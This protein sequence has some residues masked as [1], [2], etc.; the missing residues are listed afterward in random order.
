[1]REGVKRFTRTR[2][3]CIRHRGTRCHSC[4]CLHTV[5]PSPSIQR[6]SRLFTVHSLAAATTRQVQTVP[7]AH[8]PSGTERNDD[9][10]EQHHGRAG[11]RQHFIM[12]ERRNAARRIPT[13]RRHSLGRRPGHQDS[14]V[15]PR[16]AR[17]TPPASLV[18]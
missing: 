9:N 6:H 2:N 13:S 11:R 17:G 14:P 12:V 5:C 4:C 7:S 1:M 15:R 10:T 18:R 8:Q 16:T 3:I